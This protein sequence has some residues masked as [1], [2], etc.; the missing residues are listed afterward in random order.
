MSPRDIVL[1]Q[2]QAA[3]NLYQ[4]AV[5]ELSEQDTKHQPF[6]GASHVNWILAHLAVSEDGMIAQLTGKPNRL[7]AELHKCYSGGSQ[8]QS[9]DG[10]TKVEAWKL[11]TEQ[12]KL[13]EEFIKTFPEAR[14]DDASPEK[15]RAF[16]PKVGSVVGLI[17]AHPC[18]HFGQVTF[19]RRALQKPLMF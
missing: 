19:N 10:L 5:K 13:T 6:P 2:W 12:G 11:F 17:G 3:Q 7:S 8:C 1:S 4:G 14:Y 16:A 18:W 15:L 9:D